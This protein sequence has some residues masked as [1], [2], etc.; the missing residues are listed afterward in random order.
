METYD[1]SP[2]LLRKIIGELP[3][4]N[5]YPQRYENNN[6]PGLLNAGIDPSTAQRIAQNLQ[7][8]INIQKNITPNVSVVS[9]GGRIGYPFDINGN[10]VTLGLTGGGAKGET[11]GNQPK[12][13]FSKFNVT[14]GDIGYSQGDNS[15]SLQYQRMPNVG[16]IIRLIYS[17]QF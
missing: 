13:R 16:D 10:L 15:Y 17:R 6:L 12:E 7:T 5:Y 14:G 3:N 8:D 11:V 2:E 1:I 4:E 9:G